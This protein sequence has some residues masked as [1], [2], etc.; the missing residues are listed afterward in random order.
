[1]ARHGKWLVYA[2]HDCLFLCGPC[3]ARDYIVPAMNYRICPKCKQPC[4][5]LYRDTWAR[6]ERR[7]ASDAIWYLPWTWGRGHWEYRQWGHLEEGGFDYRRS[8]RNARSSSVVA[9]H[10]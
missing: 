8:M 9:M 4:G 5:L 6:V 2:Q 1:M 10:S 7:R 3:H